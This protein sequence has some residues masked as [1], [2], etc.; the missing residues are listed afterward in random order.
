MPEA[1]E[2]LA[3]SSAPVLRCKDQSLRGI[4]TV[5]A[6]GLRPPPMMWLPAITKTLSTLSSC[7]SFCWKLSQVTR[8]RCRLAPS[9]S[10]A[11]AD[12]VALVFGRHEAAGHRAE[13]DAAADDDRARRAPMMRWCRVLFS[14]SGVGAG[15]GVEEA[16]EGTEDGD[17]S[18]LVSTSSAHGPG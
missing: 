1:G 15:E 6:L 7:L 8:V 12:E 2:L 10:I 18:C 11:G 9:G 4:N 3:S 17:F 5:P 16:V 14:H 13:L